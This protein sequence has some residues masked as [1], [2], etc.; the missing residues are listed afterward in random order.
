MEKKASH[1]KNFVSPIWGASPLFVSLLGLC[2]ALA[3]TKS[4]E[5]AFGMGVLFTIVL[6]CSNVLVSALRK[7]VPIEVRTPANIVV[8]AAFVTLAR[9]LSE[10]FLPE[11]Y[12]S[13]GV[14]VSLLVVNCVILGRAEAFACKNGVYDSFLDGLGNGI[15]Y[16]IAIL[17]IALFR[18]ALGSGM[19]RFGVT[20]PFLVGGG[21]AFCIYLLKG[22]GYDVSM[23]F[24]SDPA[25]GFLVLG[26]ALAIAQ[27]IHNR[28]ETKKKVLARKTKEDAKLAAGKEVAK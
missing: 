4:I 9:M 24:F 21:E 11:L 14:F 8:I 1:L 10:A 3:V 20:F 2:P 17:I 27:A 13:L 26:I 28:K 7:L 12:S 16:T 19:I 25:G 5:S 18:E 6:V 22:P 15:G 23:R